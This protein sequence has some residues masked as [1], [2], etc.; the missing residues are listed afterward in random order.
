MSSIYTKAFFLIGKQVTIVFKNPSYKTFHMKQLCGGLKDVGLFC[1]G[2]ENY[3][4]MSRKMLIPLNLVKSINKKSK[5]DVDKWDIP[6]T[7]NDD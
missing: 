4:E 2:S 6:N 1:R 3:L 5:D 7:G